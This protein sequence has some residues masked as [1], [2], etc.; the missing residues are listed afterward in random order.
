MAED[1]KKPDNGEDKPKP[2]V[3][4]ITMRL[5]GTMEV[6]FDLIR[7]QMA[8]YGMLKLGE[9]TLD[10]FYK[11]KSDSKIVKPSQHGIM[12]FVRRKH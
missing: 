9:K 6:S 8:S 3:M 2:L 4:K 11:S 1:V 7:N 10:N 12:N 5:D